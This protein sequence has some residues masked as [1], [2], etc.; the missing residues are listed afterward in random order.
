MYTPKRVYCSKADYHIDLTD[1]ALLDDTELKRGVKKVMEVIVGL[2]KDR[3]KLVTLPILRELERKNI[4]L[5]KK[6]K[7]GVLVWYPG[8]IVLMDCTV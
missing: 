5:L 6:I 2:L 4:F 3:W 8:L 7:L 1:N